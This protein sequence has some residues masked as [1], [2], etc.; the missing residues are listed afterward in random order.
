MDAKVGQHETW[1]GTPLRG[2]GA[3][4][5][6]VAGL[7]LEELHLWVPPPSSRS[8]EG[9]TKQARRLSLLDRHDLGRAKSRA[10]SPCLPANAR[11]RSPRTHRYLTRPVGYTVLHGHERMPHCVS[12]LG[13]VPIT[14]HH[15]LGCLLGYFWPGPPSELSPMVDRTNVS[16]EGVLPASLGLR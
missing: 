11:H 10:P 14:Q 15:A 13:P 4:L 5:A 6:E 2:S 8:D 3:S 7:R 9:L 12:S 1:E 16:G